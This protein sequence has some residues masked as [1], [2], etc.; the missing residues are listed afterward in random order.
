MQDILG[1]KGHSDTR[2]S[3]PLLTPG[4]QFP[5]PEQREDE[6]A[7][8]FGLVAASIEAEGLEPSYEEAK[9]RPDW[10]KWKEARDTELK[11]L[12]E[13]GTWEVPRP[14]DHNV[15]DCKWALKIKMKN[16]SIDKYKA[17]LYPG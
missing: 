13:A 10:E 2:P 11:T 8:E 4:V 5:T 7:A 3:A 6:N 15:V 1:G 14:T 9:R 16:G 12:L 17:R